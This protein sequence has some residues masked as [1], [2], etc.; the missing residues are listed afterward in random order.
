MTAM[1]KGPFWVWSVCV[2]VVIAAC[3]SDQS[4]PADSKDSKR[5]SASSEGADDDLAG[6][7]ADS[8]APF[9]PL[10]AVGGSLVA[11]RTVDDGILRTV[12]VDVVDGTV[13]W[14]L[15]EPVDRIP[16]VPMPSVPY[17]TESGLVAV[18][19]RDADAASPVPAARSVSAAA[20]ALAIQGRD[21]VTGAIRWSVQVTGSP[22]DFPA[23]C[24]DGAAA[25]LLIEDGKGSTDLFVYDGRSGTLDE[26]AGGYERIIVGPDDRDGHG[27][28]LTIDGTRDPYPVS[29]TADYRRTPLWTTDLVQLRGDRPVHPNG[30][31]FAIVED[32]RIPAMWVGSDIDEEFAPGEVYYGAVI[33]LDSRG[34]RSYLLDDA[35]PCYSVSDAQ[36]FALCDYAFLDDGS[37]GAVPVARSVT[38]F[39]PDT[40]ELGDT[41]ALDPPLDEFDPGR[42]VVRLSGRRWLLD[43]G[44]ESVLVDLDDRTIVPADLA[45]HPYGWCRPPEPDEPLEIQTENAG[46]IPHAPGEV[47]EPCTTADGRPLPPEEAADAIQQGDLSTGGLEGSVVE[48][49]AGLVWTVDGR[50]VLG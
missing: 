16:G 17:L 36:T 35:G 7:S 49:E 4:R 26:R 23:P 42:R 32:G 8:L 47:L 40:G 6:R 19:A 24:E 15:D 43:T 11:Y 48:T 18:L 34:D 12:V 1:F 39:D 44:S 46:P 9:S 22:S 41:V 27:L 14:S 21:P 33:G 29:A 25:C 3:S 2:L 38:M 5:P 13:Q 28:E 37:G 20:E 10:I 45:D 30:G 31:W 50:L